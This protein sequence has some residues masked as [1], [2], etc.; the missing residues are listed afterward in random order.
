MDVENPFFRSKC[1]MLI[2]S[3]LRYLCHNRPHRSSP[4]LHAQVVKVCQV[5]MC[6]NPNK[7]IAYSH[8]RCVDA[9]SV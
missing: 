6:I 9:T 8:V 4:S 3:D 7:R 1:F 2:F 5:L